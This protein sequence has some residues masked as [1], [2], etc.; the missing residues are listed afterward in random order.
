M[1]NGAFF[2]PPDMRNRGRVCQIV[3]YAWNKQAREAMED[4]LS[5]Q[6]HGD[7]IMEQPSTS[8]DE[9]AR[10]VTLG[11]FFRSV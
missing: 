10:H 2:P 7:Q 11:S 4:C 5:I 9:V 8:W 6:R 3:F 1:Q